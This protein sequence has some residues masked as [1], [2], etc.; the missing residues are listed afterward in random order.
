VRNGILAVRVGA[1]A[2]IHR[3]DPRGHKLDLQL[4]QSPAK[5]KADPA[6]GG[7]EARGGVS[8]DHREAA[9]RVHVPRRHENLLQVRASGGVRQGVARGLRA[10]LR[11]RGGRRPRAWREH[12]V[13]VPG[14]HGNGRV[15]RGA[16]PGVQMPLREATAGGERQHGDRTNGRAAKG[17]RVCGSWVRGRV[18]WR[19]SG[20]GWGW[21]CGSVGRPGGSAGWR[22]MGNAQRWD[23]GGPVPEHGAR[24]G[25][26]A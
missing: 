19:G 24:A 3:A 25:T 5:G 16:C 1:E 26:V 11:A 10:N 2:S 17:G 4:G 6:G 21:R 18:S 23:V 7:G 22:A 15:S 9:R 8:E 12:D 14:F 20:R 13:D